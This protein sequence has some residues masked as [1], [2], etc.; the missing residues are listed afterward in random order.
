MAMQESY[1]VGLLLERSWAPGGSPSLSLRPRKAE[2]I[3]APAHTRKAPKECIRKVKVNRT[4]LMAQSKGSSSCLPS[5][6]YP[7]GPRPQP[8]GWA[9]SDIGRTDDFNLVSSSAHPDCLRTQPPSSCY[10][11]LWPMPGRLRAGLFAHWNPVYFVGN[12]SVTVRPKLRCENIH[13]ALG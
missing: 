8:R 5:C 11:C 1:I 2:L 6:G 13:A 3:K 12:E 4:Q 10:A 9:D 7:E